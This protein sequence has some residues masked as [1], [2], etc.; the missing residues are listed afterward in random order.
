[1]SDQLAGFPQAVGPGSGAWVWFPGIPLGGV[2]KGG[3]PAGLP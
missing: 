3:Q 2:A 1:M